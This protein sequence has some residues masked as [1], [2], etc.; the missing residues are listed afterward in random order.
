MHFSDFGVKDESELEQ[1]E[2]SLSRP[3]FG[4]DNQLTVIGWKGKKRYSKCYIVKCSKCSKD[5][6]MFGDG[7]FTIIKE[8]FNLGLIPCGCSP[9][10]RKT[11]DQYKTLIERKCKETNYRFHGFAEDFKGQNTKI[12]LECNKHGIWDTCSIN[13]Y[14][15]DRR[16]PNCREEF[17]KGGSVNRKSEEE[18]INSFVTT[19]KFKEGTK[20]WRS[21][22]LNIR[23]EKAYW[24]YTCSVCSNDEYVKAGLCSGIFEKS[25]SKLIKG[26]LGCRCSPHY[27]YNKSQYEFKIESHMKDNEDETT[28][29]GILGAFIG[30]ETKFTR[31]CKI[32]GNFNTKIEDFFH[33]GCGCPLC[34]HK[35][36]KQSYINGVYCDD[37]LIAIKFG[38]ANEYTVR[39][40]KQ[41]EKSIYN[42]INLHAYEF[43]DKESCLKSEK[44]L[45]RKLRT[46]ILSKL[47]FK[48][49]FTE[50]TSPEN[51]NYIISIFEK[52]G[53]VRKVT[54]NTKNKEAA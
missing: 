3:T 39:V 16:C 43:K 29:V 11:E 10:A 44:E 25:Q 1:D 30:V 9:I 15:Q 35:N 6:E 46:S 40:K 4:K 20:F 33:K 49:G 21:D 51:L 2:F 14:L 32:H 50:T 37:N 47:E 54:E 28:F 7:I 36:Q 8:N 5:P 52:Y 24:N 41:N 53:G 22:K 17:L 18:L 31:N 38:I 34:A 12:L 13:K 45:K 27:R 26:Y 19:G 48:D 23:K 42:V